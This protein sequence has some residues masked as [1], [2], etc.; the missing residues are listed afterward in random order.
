MSVVSQNAA[1][2]LSSVL[3]QL[4]HKMEQ[5]EAQVNEVN[6][7]MGIL[8]TTGLLNSTV[9]LGPDRPM[10]YDADTGPHDSGC[11]IQAALLVP[12]GFGICQW[13]TEEAF[14]LDRGP[15]GREIGARLKFRPFA[16]LNVADKAFLQPFMDEMLEE[17]MD[18]VD[19]AASQLAAPSSPPVEAGAFM[20]TLRKRKGP[21]K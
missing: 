10:D 12:G 1:E 21:R 6:D 18:I 19:V 2:K 20:Q 13:D 5:G 4:K 8:G 3:L 14:E 11:L 9:F 7:L 15:G 17:F 16:E